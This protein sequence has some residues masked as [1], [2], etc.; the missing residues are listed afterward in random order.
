MHFCVMCGG[1]LWNRQLYLKWRGGNLWNRQLY[2][3][4]HVTLCLHNLRQEVEICQPY[5]F[6]KS[7]TDKFFLAFRW[8]SQ[9]ILKF[10]PLILFYF[11]LKHTIP[12]IYYICQGVPKAVLIKLKNKKRLGLLKSDACHST[13]QSCKLNTRKFWLYSTAEFKYIQSHKTD[14]HKWK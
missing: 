9:G 8:A 10:I 11:K 3:K 6:Q 1:N 2:L 14:Q 12:S 5:H 13:V 7:E 4:F